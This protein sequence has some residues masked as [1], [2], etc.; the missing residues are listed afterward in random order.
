MTRRAL[1]AALVAALV[2]CDVADAPVTTCKE[3]PAGGCPLEHGLACSDPACATAYACL[4][5]AW[6]LD[7]AC[8]GRDAAADASPAEDAG[9]RD[10]SIDVPGASGGPGCAPLESPDCPLALAMSCGASCC[11]CVDLFVC[12]DGGWDLWGACSDGGP[13]PK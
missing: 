9:P 5:G 13:T 10:A 7:H 1:A 4:N 8:A 6:V 2:A 12:R 11:G 3:I